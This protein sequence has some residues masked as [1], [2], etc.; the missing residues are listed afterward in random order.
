MKLDLLS[1]FGFFFLIQVLDIFREIGQQERPENDSL[2]LQADHVVRLTV[3]EEVYSH[4]ATI[5]VTDLEQTTPK[6]DYRVNFDPKIKIIR[7]KTKLDPNSIQLFLTEI[8]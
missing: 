7:P 2:A 5:P 1:D 3:T 4:P 6:R 8:V